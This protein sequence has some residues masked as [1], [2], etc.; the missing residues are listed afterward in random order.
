M[1][2]KR[3][4]GYETSQPHSVVY[5][6][7]V[8]QTVSLRQLDTDT[9]PGCTCQLLLGPLHRL[10]RPCIS[11]RVGNS[12]VAS[13]RS[14]GIALMK[15]MHILTVL[16]SAGL[17][18]RAVWQGIHPI[19]L[20]MV[21]SVRILSSGPNEKPSLQDLSCIGHLAERPQPL[22]CLVRGY[23]VCNLS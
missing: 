20:H 15:S 11:P 16:C 4:C 8:A 9:T 22:G 6:T 13:T 19:G 21:G 12:K 7:V 1:G 17:S 23:P 5:G 10:P 14:R 18:G 3:T 2:R